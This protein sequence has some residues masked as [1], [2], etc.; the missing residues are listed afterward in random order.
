MKKLEET[1]EWRILLRHPA[2]RASDRSTLWR[3]KVNQTYHIS[4]EFPSH[5]LPEFNH[6]NRPITTQAVLISMPSK[7][8]AS[9]ISKSFN[10]K[11]VVSII[12]NWGVK[13][14]FMIISSRSEKDFLCS[15]FSFILTASMHKKKLFS[16]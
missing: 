9:L 4:M 12:W 14:Q 3:F 1:K 16:N 11:E 10:S 8:V 13:C 15:A 7:S 2:R 5:Y 6:V